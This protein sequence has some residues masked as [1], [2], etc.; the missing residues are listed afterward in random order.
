VLGGA[1]DY[2]QRLFGDNRLKVMPNDVIVAGSMLP[3]AT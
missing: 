1:G 3:Q 2:H